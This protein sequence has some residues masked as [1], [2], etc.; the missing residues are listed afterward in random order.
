MSYFISFTFFCLITIVNSFFIY[1][2]GRTVWFRSASYATARRR[3]FLGGCWVLPFARRITTGSLVLVVSTLTGASVSSAIWLMPFED[4]WV[5][6]T[7]A[8]VFVFMLGGLSGSRWVLAKSVPDIV[9]RLYSEGLPYF[10]QDRVHA[11]RL[12]TRGTI[13]QHPLRFRSVLESLKFGLVVDGV[14]HFKYEGLDVCSMH[15]C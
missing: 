13:L 8:C 9:A 15:L 11:S 3:M 5:E 4:V 2:R 14:N 12:K 1:R 10:N 6:A 7:H